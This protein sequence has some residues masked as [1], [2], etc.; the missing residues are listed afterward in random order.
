MIGQIRGILLEKLPPHLMIDVQGVGYMV[1]APLSTFF[2]LPEIGKEVVLRTHFIVREDAQ[3]LY[4]F[5]TK[6]EW[7]LFQEIIKVNGIGPKI[8]LAVL[9]GMS[10]SEFVAVIHAKSVERLQSIPGIGSKTAQRMIVEMQTSK[11][12]STECVSLGM[13][14]EKTDA[15]TALIAL[16]YKFQ[17]ATK[18]V[19]KVERT[20]LSCEHIIKEA[21]QGLAKL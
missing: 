19:S 8:A 18:A 9:S 7:S 17:E 2:S 4:G 16:G 20:G 12:L 13:S 1:Q 3:I 6:A 14:D 11:N 5:S 15:I 21:L 10:P